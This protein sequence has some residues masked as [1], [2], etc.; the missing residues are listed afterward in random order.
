MTLRGDEVP[1]GPNSVADNQKISTNRCHMVLE[2]SLGFGNES[3]G[4]LYDAQGAKQSG[5][6]FPQSLTSSAAPTQS[7][8]G[9]RRPA[10]LSLLT[11]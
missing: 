11:M 6:P 8:I 3:W 9:A 4:L 2:H 5:S 7:A 10:G 1:I